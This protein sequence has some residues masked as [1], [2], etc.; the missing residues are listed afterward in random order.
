M[1]YQVRYQITVEYIGVGQGPMSVPAQQMLL[2]GQLAITGLTPAPR[3]GGPTGVQQVPGGE[4]PTQANFNTAING[5]SST[6][7]GGLALDIENAIAANLGQ[8]QGF[9][10]GGG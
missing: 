4:S 5:S 3:T 1:S 10:T 6:A 8:I 2:L 7:S 9:A